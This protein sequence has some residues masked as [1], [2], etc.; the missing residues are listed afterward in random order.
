MV[1]VEDQKLQS[2]WR[3]F[4]WRINTYGQFHLQ[5]LLYKM[6]VK[7]FFFH[8]MLKHLRVGKFTGF[9]FGLWVAQFK[10]ITGSVLL[11]IPWLISRNYWRIIK[12][13]V[14]HMEMWHFTNISIFLSRWWR[15]WTDSLSPRC[16]SP[17]VCLGRN[18]RQKAADVTWA[19][20]EHSS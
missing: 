19:N 4:E 1:S 20:V 17:S 12:A 3:P 13:I 2:P 9:E 5:S 7:L 8:W 16:H 14:C 10:T 6:G 15:D 11:V 18:V